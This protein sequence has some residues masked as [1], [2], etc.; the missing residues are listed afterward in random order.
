MYFSSSDNRMLLLL[1]TLRLC[2]IRLR[3]KNKIEM[4]YDSYEMTKTV[5][6]SI[7]KWKYIFQA[8]KTDHKVQHSS[9]VRNLA[10]FLDENEILCVGG[11]LQDV[12]FEYNKHPSLISHEALWLRKL[13]GIIMKRHIWG[14]SGYFLLLGKS[15]G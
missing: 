6:S 14:Q 12:N 8:L 9:S 10:P 1:E 2:T 11:R 7:I 3:F 15:F 4:L 5:K 13:F